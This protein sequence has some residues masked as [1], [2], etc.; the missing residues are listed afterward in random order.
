MQ[1][2]QIILRHLR[3]RGPASG[4]RL[5]RVLGV[6]RQAVHQHL[7]SLCERGLILKEGVTR[8]ARY[9]TAG[10]GEKAKS[11]RAVRRVLNLRGLE[12]DRVF[13]EISVV[14]GLDRRA[15]EQAR[16]IAHYAF[17][18]MLNNAIEHSQSRRGLVEA[19]VDTYACSFLIR[20]YGVGVFRSMTTKLGLRDENAAL[21]ELLKGKRTTAP[22]RHT[23]EGIFFTSKAVDGITFRSHRLQLTIDNLQPDVVVE[24]T[25]FLRGTEVRFSVGRRATR[26]LKDVFATFAPEEYDFR[27]EKTRVM[28]RLLGKDYVSRSEARRLLAGLDQFKEIE[29]DFNG[30][31][32]LGQGFADEIFRVFRRAHPGA[33]MRAVNARPA[34]QAMIRHSLDNDTLNDLTIT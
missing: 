32:R 8:G 11:V 20:D 33:K 14:M 34:L 9:R 12:E 6:S 26:R 31:Q 17:T 30:V 22:E 3:R 23:G 10:R 19:R 24:E 2:A 27:F 1:T 5:A 7:K 4:S 16:E 25:R 21:F 15:G 28:V 13:G 18:E 29:L